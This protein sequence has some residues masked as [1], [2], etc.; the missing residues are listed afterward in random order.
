M[1]GSSG[2][3]KCVPAPPISVGTFVLLST[4]ELRMDNAI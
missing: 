3:V 1:S 4:N 2:D